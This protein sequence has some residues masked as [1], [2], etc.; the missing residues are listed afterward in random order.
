MWTVFIAALVAAPVLV[1]IVP[2]VLAILWRQEPFA[3]RCYL[4]ATPVTAFACWLTFGYPETRGIPTT[5]LTGMPLEMLLVVLSP[6]IVLGAG[7]PIVVAN[8][9]SRRAWRT[10]VA[11]GLGL[12]AALLEW[13]IIT[14]V[15]ILLQ[16]K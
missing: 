13:D 14:V 3:V 11:G 8:G 6:A 4:A 5:G 16:S 7:S 1:L 12:V 10:I 2:T 15:T 9:I